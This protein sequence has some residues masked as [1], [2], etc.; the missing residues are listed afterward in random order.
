MPSYGNPEQVWFTLL[1]LRMYQDVEGCE[2]LVVDN[3]GNDDTKKACCDQR[4]RYEVFTGTPGTGPVRNKAFELAT[5]PFVLVMDSHVFLYPEAIAKLKA[6]LDK[7]W[8][9]AANLIHGPLVLPGLCNA[10]THYENQWRNKTWGIWCSPVQH[11]DLPKDPFEIQ[12]MGLG[13]FGCRKDSWLGFHKDCKGYGGVEGVIHEKYRHY[14][15]KSLSLPFLKWVHKFRCDVHYPLTI[16]DRIRNFLLGF[17]EIGLDPSPIYD[18]YG[19]DL[20]GKTA[21]T[22]A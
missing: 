19:K 2:I 6:W 13:V 5:K 12:M 15:K 14:G 20:V 17:S 18:H 22:I 10:Y 8:D 7:N 9:E 21:K 1:A 16:E 11:E 4:V 3:Q